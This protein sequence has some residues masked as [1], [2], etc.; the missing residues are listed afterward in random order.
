MGHGA[1]RGYRGTL[2]LIV[3]LL[4][5]VVSAA[6]SVAELAML[7]LWVVGYFAVT[8]NVHQMT[9]RYYLPMYPALFLLAAWLLISIAW[10][11]SIPAGG[12]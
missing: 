1:G 12:G 11:R 4:Q 5:P 6:A 10:H 3:A 2:A 8:G 9:M 7:S